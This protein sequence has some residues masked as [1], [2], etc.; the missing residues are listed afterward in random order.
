MIEEVEGII[1]SETL[2]GETS[3]IINVFTRKYG[4]IGI[5]AKGAKSMKSPFRASTLTFNHGVFHIKYKENK[6][7]TL[8]SVDVINYYKNIRSD[9]T[10]MG[11]LVYIADLTKQ[12]LK[13]TYNNKIYDLFISILL[14]LEEGLEPLILSNILEIKL[15]D[16]L[17]VGINLNECAMCGTKGDIITVDPSYGGLICKKCFTNNQIVDLKVLKLLRMYY[18]VDVNSI[19]NIKIDKHI[20]DEIDRLLKSYYETYTG[21][22]LKNKTFL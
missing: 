1:L 7:S 13:E 11:Y 15:L 17:G 6:L 4:V 3:K 5:M 21:I 8:V 20:K 9:L 22:Y 16:Y 2:Y 12:V 10:S 14:K 19:T 18:L